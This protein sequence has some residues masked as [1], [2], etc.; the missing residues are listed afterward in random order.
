MNVCNLLVY[1]GQKANLNSLAWGIE[2]QQWCVC[3][4]L[5]MKSPYDVSE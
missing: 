5:G 2:G 3:P 4:F 1:A